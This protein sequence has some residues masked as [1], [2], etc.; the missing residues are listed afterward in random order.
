MCLGSLGGGGSDGCSTAKPEALLEMLP[1][2]APTGGRAYLAQQETSCDSLRD[3][4]WHG[5][6]CCNL[7]CRPYIAYFGKNELETAL[8]AYT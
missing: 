7:K 3:R 2:E 5:Q 6:C 4:P 8:Y 1:G